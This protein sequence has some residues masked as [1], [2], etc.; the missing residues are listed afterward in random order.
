MK[1]RCHCLLSRVKNKT[2]GHEH[3]LLFCC[4]VNDFDN[5][6]ECVVSDGRPYPLMKLILLLMFLVNRYGKMQPH[7]LLMFLVNR[8]GKMQPHDGARWLYCYI[9]CL[10]YFIGLCVSSS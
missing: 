4:F 7:L 1:H 8:Y 6:D 5:G 2:R 10:N 9:F 3:A